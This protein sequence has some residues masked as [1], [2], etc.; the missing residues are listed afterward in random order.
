M[1]AV[2]K[3][4]NYFS[5]IERIIISIVYIVAIYIIGAIIH[6][7]WIPINFGEFTWFIALISYLIF[8][9]LTAPFFP[10]QTD[11]F[12]ERLHTLLLQFSKLCLRSK[13]LPDSE[14]Q[15]NNP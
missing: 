14:L 11:L 10:K 7:S 8:C 15:H 13:Y 6:G 12:F 3:N 9:F 4:K 1:K 5:L 2:I